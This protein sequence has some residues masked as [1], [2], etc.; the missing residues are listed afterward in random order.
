MVTATVFFLLAAIFGHACYVD[1]RVTIGPFILTIVGFAALTVGGWLG[2]ALTF[3]YGARV[4]SLRSRHPKREM[5]SNSRADGVR[6][7]LSWSGGKDSALAL[8]TLRRD[9]REPEALLTTVT[10]TYDRVSMHGVRRVLLARQ[11]EALRI[12]LVEVPIPPRAGNDLYEQRVEQAF[13]SEPLAGVDTI[14]YGDLFLEE[15]RAYREQRLAAADRRGLFP[16]WGL[17]TAELAEQF[18]DAGFEATLVCVDPRRLDPSFAGR[19]FDRQLLADLPASADPCGENGEFH[20]FVHAGPLLRTPIACTRGQ[21]LDRDGFVFCDLTP[22]NPNRAVAVSGS[23]R[24][25][26]VSTG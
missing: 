1:A 3:V 10:E 7:A 25:P 16:L 13:A 22:D 8:W 12:P 23:L 20:T 17:D 18:I 11:A 9:G 4:L 14:A 6:F 24:P 26:E 21:V 5:P 15:V 19:A 2:G